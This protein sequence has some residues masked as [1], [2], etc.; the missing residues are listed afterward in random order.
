MT[1]PDGSRSTRSRAGR[2]RTTR[3]ATRRRDRSGCTSRP[4]T[5]TTTRAVTRPSTCSRAIPAS[6][7]CGGTARRSAS[8]SRRRPTAVHLRRRPAV[9]RRLRRRVDRLRRQPVRRLARYGPVPHLPLRGG[10]AVRRRAL[11]DARRTRAPRRLRKS[12]GGFGAMITPMLRP[13]LFGGFA[14][15]AGDSLYELCYVPGF[16]KVA[17]TSATTTRA[18]TSASGRTSGHDRR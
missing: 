1:S 6:S 15:H 10:R 9:H 12:S 18:R 4:G 16:G 8:R 13:D 7:R 11:P 3:S 5:T 14:S 2:C 17:R